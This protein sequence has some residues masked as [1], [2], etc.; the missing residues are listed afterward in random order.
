M[1][2]AIIAAGSLGPG[3]HDSDHSDSTQ[4]LEPFQPTE[5]FKNQLAVV[6]K[7]KKKSSRILKHQIN[8]N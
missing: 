2:E 6:R 5:S 4:D 3:V 8:Q 1:N 7:T